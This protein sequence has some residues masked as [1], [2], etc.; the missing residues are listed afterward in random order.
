MRK[1][2]LKDLKGELPKSRKR[3]TTERNQDL[4]FS[5]SMRKKH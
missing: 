4:K 3:K 2:H 1:N 5:N